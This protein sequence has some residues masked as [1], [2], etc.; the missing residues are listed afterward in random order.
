MGADS[1]SEETEPRGGEIKNQWNLL[2]KSKDI[3]FSSIICILLQSSTPDG[4]QL[5]TG[6]LGG[7]SLAKFH[8]GNL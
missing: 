6:F 7:E 8:F 4:I 1:G 2:F 5:V 3:L